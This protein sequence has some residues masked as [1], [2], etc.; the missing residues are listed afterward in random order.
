MPRKRFWT[1]SALA[2]GT[3]AALCTAL[4]QQ[5]T[6]HAAGATTRAATVTAGGNASDFI[7]RCFFN[8]NIAPQ[9]PIDNPGSFH[10]DNLYDFFGNMAGGTSTFPG[11]QSGDYSVT[12]ATME[13]NRLSPQTNCQDTKDTAAYWNPSPYMVDSSQSGNPAPWQNTNGCSGSSS[14]PCHATGSNENFHMRVYYIPHNASDQEIP[15]GTIMITGFPNGCATVRQGFPPD[16]CSSGKSYP[17][18]T[19]VITYAC[20]A[21]SGN[22]LGTPLSA[23]PYD[24]TPFLDGD[25]SFS[26]GAVAMVRFPYCWDGQAHFPAPN[27]PLSAPVMVPGYVA[28]WI[29]YS[30]W[31]K[32]TGLGQRPTNDFAYPNPDGTCPSGFQN[33]SVVQLEERIHLLTDGAGWGDPSSC[34]GDTGLD[35]NSSRNAESSNNAT[36]AAPGGD[37]DHDANVQ[38]GPSLWVPY[39]C[40]TNVMV[41]DPNPGATTLSFA[42]SHSGDPNCNIPL[43]SP[44]TCAGGT[45]YAGAYKPAAKSYGWETLHADYWQTWQEAQNALDDPN[46][47]GLDNPSDVG[48]FGDVVDDCVTDGVKCTPAFIITSQNSPPQVY[49]GG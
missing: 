42:C 8:K 15:D 17:V 18:D 28:P 20:G 11:I 5:G 13:Q 48:T 29:V 32:Y 21:D 49:G 14:D 9:N 44:S 36:D 23:W 16:G 25:D 2:L 35:W 10:D 47:G 45:C 7:V 43:S 27:S 22:N 4:A 24:C 26:D 39:Q 31:K 30:T 6:A 34:I 46:H 37:G 41:P 1:K 38:I 33:N 40:P 3:A 12:G 19:S